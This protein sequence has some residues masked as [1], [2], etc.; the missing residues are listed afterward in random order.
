MSTEIAKFVDSVALVDHHCHGVMTHDLDRATFEDLM[1]ESSWPSPAGTTGFDSQVGLS[2]LRKCGPVLGLPADCTPEQYLA[3]RAEL[4]FAQVN[5]LLLTA[6][7][8]DTLLLDTGYRGDD[9]FNVPQMAEVAGARTAEVVRL[10]RVAEDVAASISGPSGFADAY[11]TALAEALVDAVGTKTIV[12]YRYGLDFDPER[13][14]EDEVAAAAER[15]FAGAEHPSS[16]LE[17]PVLLRFVIWCGVDA[18]L[19]MQFHVGY[20]D[21]DVELHRCDPLLMTRWL[22]ATRDLGCDVLLLH[23]YPYHREAGYLAQ[24]YPHVYCDVGLALNYTGARSAA[25]V[26]ESLELTPFYKALFSTDAFGLPELYYLGAYWFRR[27]LTQALSDW[28]REGDITLSDAQRI[29][30]MVGYA[31]TRRVYRL[32]AS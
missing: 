26:A 8:L 25:V 19:P 4:G 20:G 6:A 16:R 28:H 21:S 32:D 15:W 30:E 18:K 2:M 31:N 24:V 29:A 11:R 10:E 23:C 17:D 27:G 5:R 1:T 12:A 3:R 22:R 7:R 14:S 9:I 13:P